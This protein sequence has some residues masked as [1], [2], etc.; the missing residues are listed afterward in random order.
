MAEAVDFAHGKAKVADHGGADLA[1]EVGQ[2]AVLRIR[3]LPGL[4]AVIVNEIA[5]IA[6]ACV[7]RGFQVRA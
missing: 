7:N 3:I 1:A 5:G 2:K 6:D 4:I